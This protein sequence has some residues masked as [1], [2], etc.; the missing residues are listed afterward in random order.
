MSSAAQIDP[1]LFGGAPLLRLYRRCG[2]LQPNASWRRGALLALC[3]GWVPLAL[4]TIAQGRFIASPDAQSFLPNLAVQARYLL[5]LPLLVMAGPLLAARLREIVQHFVAVGIVRAE[6]HARFRQAVAATGRRVAS[7][8]AEIVAVGLSYVIAA[9]LM[10]WPLQELPRWQLDP[11]QPAGLSWAGWWQLL[12]SLPLLLIAFFGMLWRWWLWIQ[13]LW[14]ISRMNLLLVAAHPDGIAGL[15]FANYSVRAAA[16]YGLCIGLIVAGTVANSVV[17]EHASPLAYGH[18]IGGLLLLVVVL[19]ASPLLLFTPALNEAWRRG[20]FEYGALAERVG[21]ELE[22][23]WFRRLDSIDADALG[24]QD[25]S[26]TT[27][28]YSVVANVYRMRVFVFDLQSALVLAGATLIPFVPVTLFAVPIDTLL[29][30]AADVL[31]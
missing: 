5:G 7:P 22:R 24:R 15:R 9:A 6:D 21:R 19:F 13:L 8:L 16:P 25:F 31:L 3:I 20:I 11:S 12:V 1:E 4:L 14:H 26:A 18:L 10:L 29:A 2:L 27:D 30:R 28:L 23:Q 17:Y